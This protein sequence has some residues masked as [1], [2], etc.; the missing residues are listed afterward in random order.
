MTIRQSTGLRNLLCGNDGFASAFKNGE[1]RIYT[2]TQPATADAA[3]TG[4]LL[5]VVTKDGAARVAEVQIGRA[6]V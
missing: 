6:H 1:I 2:G 4:T 3:V 5:G